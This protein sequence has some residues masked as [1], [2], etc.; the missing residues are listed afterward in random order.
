MQPKVIKKISSRL[1]SCFSVTD[2][3]AGAT[4]WEELKGFHI[5]V[6]AEGVKL[7]QQL[8]PSIVERLSLYPLCACRSYRQRREG[9]VLYTTFLPLVYL[10]PQ[11]LRMAPLFPPLPGKGR[12]GDNAI[13]PTT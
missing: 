1:T 4:P 5:I 7:I 10:E 6:V 3:T 13:R 2:R 8:E 9:R 12:F 11:D